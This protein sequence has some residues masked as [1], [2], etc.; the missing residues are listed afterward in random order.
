VLAGSTEQPCL[1][2]FR[3]CGH[4]CWLTPL[5]FPRLWESGS[6]STASAAPSPWP[7]LSSHSHPF[8]P[9]HPLPSQPVAASRAAW[10][11]PRAISSF[12]SRLC[13]SL[14]LVSRG[15]PQEWVLGWL[16]LP[17]Q[18]GLQA[19]PSGLGAGS[20]C[21]LLCLPPL[22]RLHA[23]S[24]IPEASPLLPGCLHWC[25]P[26][27]AVLWEMQLPP[28]P[29]RARSSA[30]QLCPSDVGSECCVFLHRPCRDC[31]RFP[32]A[33]W[34]QTSAQGCGDVWEGAAHILPP[35]PSSALALAGW[36]ERE[37]LGEVETMRV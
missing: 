30:A 21:P 12:L 20:V 2:A 28:L 29:S 3:R 18:S 4:P 27:C 23:R 33:A 34:Q 6:K 11:N 9:G 1:A 36:G 15:G 31:R 37:R 17:A 22:A 26:P 14:P 25:L 5:S 13:Y 35:T 24:T 19:L 16:L 10:P 32:P 8:P 7:Q